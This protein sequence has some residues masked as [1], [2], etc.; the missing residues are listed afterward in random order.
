MRV[1]TRYIYY[2]CILLAM[3]ISLFTRINEK[4]FLI[5]EFISLLTLFILGKFTRT[6]YELR[7]V[8]NIEMN[9]NLFKSITIIIFIIINLMV[10]LKYIIKKNISLRNWY[11]DFFVLYI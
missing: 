1:H 7:E 11:A 9:I 2:V 5:V 6:F 4:I 8:L 3:I 10:F